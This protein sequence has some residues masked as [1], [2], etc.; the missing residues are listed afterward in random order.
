M[1]GLPACTF[2][3][4]AAQRAPKSVPCARPVRDPSQHLCSAGSSRHVLGPARTFRERDIWGSA[5]LRAGLHTSLSKVLPASSFAHAGDFIGPG[6]S[7]PPKLQLTTSPS[8]TAAATE[9]GT[10]K[11]PNGGVRLSGVCERHFSTTLLLHRLVLESHREIHGLDVFDQGA[12][13]DSVHTRFS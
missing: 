6:L 8:G 3:N 12:D 1:A 10:T 9:L 11:D 13:R 5:A 2:G 4:S 7:K